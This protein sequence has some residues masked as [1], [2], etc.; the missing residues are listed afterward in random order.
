MRWTVIVE[1][2]TA[3]TWPATVG[4]TTWISVIVYVPSSWR[5]WRNAISSPTLRSPTAIVV[6]ARVMVVSLVTVIVRV[7]PSSVLSERFEP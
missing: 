5:S 7:Q 4:R 3:V 2:S 6:P 1:P